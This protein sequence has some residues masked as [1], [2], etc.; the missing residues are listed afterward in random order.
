MT[1]FSTISLIQITCLKQL[2]LASEQD[3]ISSK[4]AISTAK[5]C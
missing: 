3:Y 1:L 5:H 4:D 2:I